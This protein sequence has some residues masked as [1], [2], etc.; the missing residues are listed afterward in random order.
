MC[1][2]SWFTFCQVFNVLRTNGVNVQMISQG[3]SKV[4]FKTTSILFSCAISGCLEWYIYKRQWCAF[5]VGSDTHI[6]SLIA[7]EMWLNNSAPFSI[8][9][10]KCIYLILVRLDLCSFHGYEFV[11]LVEFIEGSMPIDSLAFSSPHTKRFSP[12]FDRHAGQHLLD[13]EWWRGRAVR[14]SSPFDILRKQLYRAGSCVRK[15]KWFCS[16]IITPYTVVLQF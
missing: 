13:R 1:S 6:R 8:L 15:W 12:F 7:L 11:C 10:T 4:S 2:F 14:E 3:A 5:Q 16:Y 9:W